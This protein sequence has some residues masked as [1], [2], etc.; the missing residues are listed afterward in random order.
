MTQVLWTQRQDVGPQ[1]RVGHAMAY[2]A[3][4]KR[5]VLVGGDS[6]T[7][8]LLRDTWEWD[9]ENWTQVADM[10]PSPRRESAVVYDSAR[11]KIVLFGGRGA[12]AR[13]GDT[14]EWNGELWT[15]VADDGPTPR[16]GHGMAFDLVMKR[17]TLF[18]GESQPAALLGDTWDWDGQQWVQREDTGPSARRS[19][20]MAY[21]GRRSRVVLFGGSLAG[22]LSG[23]DTW[24]WDTARWTEVADFGP[25]S[26]LAASMAF[27]GDNVVLFGGLQA[28]QPAPAPR[29]LGGT[30]EW[31]GKRWTQR[32]DIGPSSR[33]LHAM[34]YDPDRQSTVL[35][36]GLSGFAPE[37]DLTLPDRLLGDT[38]ELPSVSDPADRELVIGKAAAVFPRDGSIERLSETA[39]GDLVADAIRERSGAQIA[40]V[41]GGEL[42]SA[43]PSSYQPSNHGLH[44]PTVGYV[45]AAPFDIVAGDVPS[46]LPFGSLVF[47]RQ[48]TGSQLWA[49]LEHSVASQ[50]NASGGFAQVSGFRLIYQ[51]SAAPGGRLRSV[52]LDNGTDVAADAQTL[53]GLAISGF[54]ATGGDG[55]SVPASG[56]GIPQETIADVLLTYIQRHGTLSPGTSDRITQLP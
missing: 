1:P 30:W 14:W 3:T 20:A 50:P 24:L 42:R 9:G 10:G 45:E 35:F 19:H 18:G 47:T 43:L 55:Y 37:G 7:A 41:T 51:L 44:R 39:L 52:R 34:A 38:W 11:Q 29:V 16:A 48:I 15:Q 17:T 26:C 46:I 25:E 56:P 6:L 8:G 40:I 27:K 22:G 36:G 13:F 5:V 54:A 23:R 49:L 32:Q 4:R 28:A 53:L 33:W 12:N 31:D 21:D 2:D